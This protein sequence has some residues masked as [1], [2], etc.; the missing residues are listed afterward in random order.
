MSDRLRVL[1]TDGQWRKSLAIVRALGKRGHTVEVAGE[2][3][4]TTSFFSKYCSQKWVFPTAERDRDACLAALERTLAARRYDLLIPTEDETVAICA[5]HRAALARHTVVPLPDYATVLTAADKALT[6]EAA[7]SCGV[8]TPKTWIFRDL[9]D[10][11]RFDGFDK[12]DSRE[13]E[14]DMPVLIKPRRSSGSRG[15]RRVTDREQLTR[16]YRE[17]H[18]DHPL[19]LIQEAIP[20]GGAARGVSVLM[21]RD[22]EVWASFVHERIRE[23]PVTGG[24]ST[25]RVSVHD[26]ELVERSVGLLRSIGWIGMAIDEFK[27]D[28]RDAEFKFL[29]INPRFVGSLQLAIS[30]GVDFPN[31][32]CLA[33]LGGTRQP[34]P[35]YPDGVMCRWLLPGDLLH[36][37]SNPKRMS[38]EPSFFR[39]RGPNLSYDICSWDDFG[40]VLGR[41][42]AMVAL[43]F[44]PEKRAMVFGRQRDSPPG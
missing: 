12:L 32:L 43:S 21:D 29:E 6:F 3:W 27:Q 18:A 26:P 42:L 22:G 2:T 4:A 11:E 17:V 8:P 19:P 33:F 14:I 28:P 44:D 41:A 35:E 25:L 13:P 7:R 40:P 34:A 31:L 36:F 20:A 5:E 38:L 37:A 15:I 9:A 16:I 10:F 23:Y 1:V 24:P 39:F 30:A